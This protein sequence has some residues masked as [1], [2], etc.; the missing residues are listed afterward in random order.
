M[1]VLVPHTP[2][3]IGFRLSF[4][5]FLLRYKGG[6]GH[7]RKGRRQCFNLGLGGRHCNRSSIGGRVPHLLEAMRP[8]NLSDGPISSAVE[9]H[10]V[11]TQ[12]EILR[13]SAWFGNPYSPRI[14][15]LPGRQ[16]RGGCAL[17]GPPVVHLLEK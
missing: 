12:R 3:K 10:A 17:Q 16:S 14:P 7:G 6:H 1:H 5:R 13:A 8:D 9:A 2:I 4:D 11:E 15:G